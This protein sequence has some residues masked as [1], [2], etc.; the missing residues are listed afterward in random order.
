MKNFY[1]KSSS[2]ISINRP[3][4]GLLIESKINAMGMIKVSAASQ[5]ASNLLA[6]STRRLVE[7]LSMKVEPVSMRLPTIQLTGSLANMQ[8]KMALP[9]CGLATSRIPDM[10]DK[11]ILPVMKI[12]DI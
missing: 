9:N 8:F 11:Y 3:L 5:L 6:S 12:R 1:I 4:S 2:L 10:L 7:G